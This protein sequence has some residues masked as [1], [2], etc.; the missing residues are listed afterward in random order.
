[1]SRAAKDRFGRLTA[2][3]RLLERLWMGDGLEQMRLCFLEKP[4]LQRAR[5]ILILGE[6][7]GRFL[8]AAMGRLPNA[9]FTVVDMSEKMLERARTRLNGDE[10]RRVEFVC[11]DALQWTF[12]RDLVDGLVLHCFLD[13]FD[14]ETLKA[15]L[16]RWLATVVPGGWVW[17]GD[18]VEPSGLGLRWLRLRVLYGFFGFITGIQAR[19]VYDVAHIMRES[20]FGQVVRESVARGVCASTLY[21]SS[22]KD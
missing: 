16:P 20:G 22:T 11:A 8:K 4:E 1:M 13:C 14:A 21:K 9:R 3:Y 12:E 19:R 18:F 15:H 2:V 5:K 6:G 7:D 17:I 10:L